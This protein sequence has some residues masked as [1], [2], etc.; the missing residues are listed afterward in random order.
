MIRVAD[1][2][3][4]TIVKHGVDHVFWVTGGGAIEII[5]TI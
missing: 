5:S 2:I 3:A 4:Q 1:Y